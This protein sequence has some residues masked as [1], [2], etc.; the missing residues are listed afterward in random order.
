MQ[1]L[2]NFNSTYKQQQ[3]I[4]FTPRW[5]FQTTPPFIALSL[6]NRYSSSNVHFDCNI[7][8]LHQFLAPPLIRNY[9]TNHQI[10]AWDI[11]NS[12]DISMYV[13]TFATFPRDHNR[14]IWNCLWKCPLWRVRFVYLLSQLVPK[15]NI[16]HTHQKVSEIEWKTPLRLFFSSAADSL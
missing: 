11:P 6:L 12:H 15:G 1:I 4:T 14:K 7:S 10:D 2:R 3:K 5:K 8:T 16:T 9:K 13:F